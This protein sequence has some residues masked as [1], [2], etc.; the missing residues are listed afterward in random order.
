MCKG[1]REWRI[2]AR[3]P[4][5][6]IGEPIPYLQP[7]PWNVHAEPD[8]PAATVDARFVDIRIGVCL[9]GARIRL[10]AD[11]GSAAHPGK[12]AVIGAL[13]QP[14]RVGRGYWPAIAGSS[15]HGADVNALDGAPV[16]RIGVIGRGGSIGGGKSNV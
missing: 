2:T 5:N 10:I 15:G 16:A 8:I 4:G 6:G 14:A 12:E 11:N 3:S 7:V 13:V 9:H 1:D